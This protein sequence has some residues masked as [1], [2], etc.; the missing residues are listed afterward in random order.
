MLTGILPLA[1]VLFSFKQKEMLTCGIHSPIG[2]WQN[3]S[4]CTCWS[5][6]PA[7]NLLCR[8][9]R[10]PGTLLVQLVSSAKISQPAVSHN[11]T[12]TS[13]HFCCF[14]YIKCLNYIFIVHIICAPCFSQVCFF[15]SLD[16]KSGCLVTEKNHWVLLYYLGFC[17]LG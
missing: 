1:A 9:T 6:N 11:L 10:W 2:F 17:N 4:M 16:G 5:T 3:V 7:G 12:T 14:S 15:M 13:S 8:A